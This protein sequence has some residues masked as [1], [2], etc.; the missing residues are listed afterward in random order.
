MNFFPINAVFHNNKNP[1]EDILQRKPKDN[2]EDNPEDNLEDKPEDNP[3][4]NPGDNLTSM[5]STFSLQ[6][7][8]W[9]DFICLER[10]GDISCMVGAIC[11]SLIFSVHA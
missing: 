4:D 11:E 2:L 10:A 5:T 3:E 8:M 9:A 1:L 7:F 6:T